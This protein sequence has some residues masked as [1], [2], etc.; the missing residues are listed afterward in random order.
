M[1]WPTCWCARALPEAVAERAL[2]RWRDAFGPVPPGFDADLDRAT[3]A[4]TFISTGFL[5][6]RI[7]AGTD[8][9]R[10]DRI[11]RRRAMLQHRLTTA[12]GT[13][14]LADLAAELADALRREYG[15][16]PLALA[17]AFR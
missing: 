5:L 9:S 10:D 2:T 7:L 14:P 4:W 11:P 17:P 3:L 6:R 8:S 12:P 15:D 1:P 13:G 16:H